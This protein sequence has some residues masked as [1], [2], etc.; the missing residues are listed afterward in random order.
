[1]Q[2]IILVCT[3]GTFLFMSLTLAETIFKNFQLN[4]VFQEASL[5]WKFFENWLSKCQGHKKKNIP[6]IQVDSRIIT[7]ALIRKQLETLKLLLLN[8]FVI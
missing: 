5:E 4:G 1:M 2:T 6:F 7:Y 3:K 8:S